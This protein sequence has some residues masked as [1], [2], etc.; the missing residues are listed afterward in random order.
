[1]IK[2]RIT[3]AFSVLAAIVLIVVARY[4][5]T[6]DIVRVTDAVTQLP[7]QGARVVPVYPSMD[8]PG[9]VTDRKGLARIGGFGLPRGGYGIYVSAAGYHTNFIPTRP[10]SENHKGWRGEHMDVS[11]NPVAKP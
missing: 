10:T 11:L 4:L 6:R 5:M 9:F 8:G 1:M 3:I 7:I 2:K